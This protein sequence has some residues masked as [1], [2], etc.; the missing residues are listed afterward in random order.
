[1]RRII[2]ALILSLIAAPVFAAAY[3][4]TTG[5][6]VIRESDGAVIPNDTRNTDWQ[7][8]QA[9]LALGNKPD[10]APAPSPLQQAQTTYGAMILNGITITCATGATIC[11]PAITGTYPLDAATQLKMT[12]QAASLAANKT[13]TNGGTTRPWPDTSGALHTFTIAQWQEFQTVTAAYVD[14]LETE[15][16][17]AQH[18]ATPSWPTS[19]SV[20]LQ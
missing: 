1:M 14:V 5:T 12:A 18:G 7:A 20:A 11:T 19:S 4:L 2:L 15:L 13:F 10:P 8:Y 17:I 16:E 9:W 3:Q 6:T